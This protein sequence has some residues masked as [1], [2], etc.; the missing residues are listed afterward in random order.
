MLRV[1]FAPGLD[2]AAI[3]ADADG[4]DRLRDHPGAVELGDDAG[5]SLAFTSRSTWTQSDMDGLVSRFEGSVSWR[6]DEQSPGLGRGPATGALAII[7]DQG[8]DQFMTVADVVVMPD[9]DRDAFDFTTTRDASIFTR[10]MPRPSSRERQRL[11][12]ERVV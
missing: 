8:A 4:L 12:R 7:R 2:A 10:P 9:P 6:H 1:L 3:E 11:G 5:R